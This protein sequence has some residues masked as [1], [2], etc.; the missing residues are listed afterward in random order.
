MRTQDGWY[1]RK[2]QPN[3]ESLINRKIVT[4]QP[5]ANSLPDLE[6]VGSV[7]ETVVFGRLRV[8]VR[9]G[10]DLVAAAILLFAVL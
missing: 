3:A 1:F 10:F 5:P 8:V 6:N 2:G 9:K 4:V 7:Q